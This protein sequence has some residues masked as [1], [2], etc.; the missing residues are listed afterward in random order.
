MA[1]DDQNR[2]SVVPSG[3]IIHPVKECYRCHAPI[4][5]GLQHCP[6]CKRPQ[7][8]TCYCGN[9]IPITAEKCPI[10]GA[11]WRHS[12]RVT[13][14]SRKRQL[15]FNKLSKFALVGALTALVVGIMGNMVIKGMAQQ[16]LVENE[17]LPDSY[18]ERLKLAAN[19]TGAVLGTLASSIA[20]VAGGLAPVL[21]VV[22]G[23]A[24][25]GVLIYM[26]HEDLIKIRWPW[27]KNHHSRRRRA[28]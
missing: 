28:R 23:G 1:P 13:R 8:R 19:A 21:L 2:T 7:Y 20:F 26:I 9:R 18:W 25:L 12:H 27:K 24:G 4:P 10:C 16:S 17:T 15:N 14:K 5:E 6:K 11:D 3:E 22:L